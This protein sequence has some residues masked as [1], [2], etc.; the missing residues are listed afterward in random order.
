MSGS[1]PSNRPDINASRG[2]MFKEEGVKLEPAAELKQTPAPSKRPEMKGPQTSDID[3]ILS[4]LKT[5][6]SKYSQ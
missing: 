2:A 6:T 5:R 3:N 4:G 1:A